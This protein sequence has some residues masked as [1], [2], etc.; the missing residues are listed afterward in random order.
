M[1]RGTGG[2]GGPHGPSLT[3]RQGLIALEA[4]LEPEGAVKRA[5]ILQ[6]RHVQHRHLGHHRTGSRLEPGLGPGPG[7]DPRLR[8]VGSA[9]PRRAQKLPPPLR[10]EMGICSARLL[11]RAGHALWPIT[12]NALRRRERRPLSQSRSCG[13]RAPGSPGPIRRAPSRGRGSSSRLLLAFTGNQSPPSPTRVSGAWMG[14]VRAR[15]SSR[16]IPRVPAP[17]R[18]SHRLALPGDASRGRQRRQLPSGGA[19]RSLKGVGKAV[20]E[21][22]VIGRREWG[23]D[24]AVS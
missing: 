13:R 11:Q 23:G 9:G 8:L 6:H 5:R 12:V 10:G 17:A 14:G 3:I 22:A 24:K 21:P 16:P 19:R 7:P 4:D 2:S 18:P 1:T 20:L 15:G